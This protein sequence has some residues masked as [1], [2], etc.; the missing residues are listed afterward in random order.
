MKETFGHVWNLFKEFFSNLTYILYLIFT[1][2][3]FYIVL[4]LQSKVG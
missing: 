4:Y 2:L 3:L 1:L